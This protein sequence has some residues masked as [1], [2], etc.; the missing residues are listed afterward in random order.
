MA[1]VLFMMA[2]GYANNLL[3]MIVFFLSAVALQSIYLTN[4]NVDR[5]FIEG[6]ASETLFAEPNQK[7]RVFL[8]NKKNKQSYDVELRADKENVSKYQLAGLNEEVVE[9]KW[10][11]TSRG[12]Q[13][14]P[15]ITLQ[16]HFPFGLLRAWKVY[17]DTKMVL[18]YPERRGQTTYPHGAGGE[19][20]MSELGLFREHSEY[21]A[22]D[23]VRRIDWRKSVKLR[24]LLVRKLESE[25]QRGVDFKWEQT[26]F[27]ETIEDR[28]SQLALWIDQAESQ[29]IQYSL[30]VDTF[31]AHR[32]REAM[33]YRRCMEFLATYMKES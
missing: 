24:K 17:R 28:L 22:N 2:L 27:L 31:V 7:I 29:G 4:L 18:I 30:T 13:K 26:E 33:H 9:V 12:W 25:G 19:D 5:I 1:L 21:Q 11:P 20:R 23:S 8:N 14:I 32:D 10:H 6:T 15:A 16:S 3:Y